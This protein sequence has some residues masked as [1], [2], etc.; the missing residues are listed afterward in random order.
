M[1]TFFSLSDYNKQIAFILWLFSKTQNKNY[2]DNATGPFVS[3]PHLKPK[4]N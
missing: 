1:L 2:V 3:L 4:P